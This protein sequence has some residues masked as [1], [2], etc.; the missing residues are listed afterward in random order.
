M[1][2]GMLCEH[3]AGFIA[4]I[5]WVNDVPKLTRSNNNM[6]SHVFS[7]LQVFMIVFMLRHLLQSQYNQMYTLQIL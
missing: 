1:C 5:S 7:G 3:A 4:G 2:P 6:T